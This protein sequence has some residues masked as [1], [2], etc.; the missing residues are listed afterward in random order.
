MLLTVENIDEILAAQKKI[1]GTPTWIDGQKEKTSRIKIPLMIND[2]VYPQL[3]LIATAARFITPQR[4]NLQLVL[5]KPIERMRFFP[6]SPHT[7]KISKNIPSKYRGLVMLPDHHRYYSWKD[8]RRWPRPDGDNLDFARPIEEKIGTCKE[9][10]NYF[11][12]RVRVEGQ[13]N[14]PPYEPRLV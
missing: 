8:N 6:D 4:L 5:Y 9:A 7:N 12:D 11:L 3:F 1:A 2:E 10:I 13:F 14:S